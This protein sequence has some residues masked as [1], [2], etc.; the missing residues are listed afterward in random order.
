[1]NVFYSKEVINPNFT[2]YITY[3]FSKLLLIKLE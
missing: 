1:M 2:K 3:N